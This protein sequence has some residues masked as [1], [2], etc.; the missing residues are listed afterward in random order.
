[1][2]RTSVVGFVMALLLFV[3]TAD[4]DAFSVVALRGGN[5]R[6]FWEFDIARNTWKVLP[7]TPALVGPGGA[8]ARL[9]RLDHI[10]ALRGGG[11]TDFWRFE[12][13]HW[14]ALAPTPGPVG[15][16]GGL[17][18]INYGTL[19]ERDVLY[20]LQGG[21]S[22]AI[23]RY[24]VETDTWEALPV[25]VLE[26]VGAGGALSSPNLG[27]EGTL[28]VLPGGGSSNVH[29]LDVA[30]NSWTLIATTP[31]PVGAGGSMSHDFNDCELAFAGAGST[32]FFSTGPG[33]GPGGPP[34]PP[35]S[36]T[37]SL[38]P[39]PA[40]VGAGGALA[41]ALAVGGSPEDL[42]FA[43]RGGGTSDFWRYSISE[44]AWTVMP[45]APASVGDGGAL[46]QVNEV[47]RL[48]VL[49]DIR[50]GT[51]PNTIRLET[52]RNVTAAILGSETFHAATVDPLTVTLADAPIR[53]RLNGTP[54]AALEDVNGDGRLDL[55][56]HVERSA[57]ALAPA[58]D[59]AVLLG[60]TFD[61]T[62][63]RGADFVEVVP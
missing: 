16:G 27:D 52:G 23:W 44:N 58:D 54:M 2:R 45:P 25:P 53:L 10:Y 56:F 36:P 55:V 22:S 11:T 47:P 20:A 26:P 17:V 34:S 35:C 12:F 48:L 38:A 9:Q 46:V 21:G 49:I 3:L 63:I 13:G 40:S 41:T 61:G 42:V 43:L 14:V 59:Q 29:S 50:P 28:D 15:A 62:L 37:T 57:L 19:S 4:L 8:V 31:S 24:D 7:P 18:G 32:N 30:T 6:E 39:A 5:T 60:E 51:F 33:F 1:M